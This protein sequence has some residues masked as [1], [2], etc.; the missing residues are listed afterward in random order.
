MHNLTIETKRI[1]KCNFSA[2]QWG[3]LTFSFPRDEIEAVADRLNEYLASYVNDGSY[4]KK[5]VLNGMHKFM[6]D[7][8]KYGAMDSE[9]RM[10]LDCVLDEIYK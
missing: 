10:F 1:V 7:R 9:P 8:S 5:T 3:L 6:S 2:D 4:D